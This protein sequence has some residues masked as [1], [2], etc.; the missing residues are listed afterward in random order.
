MPALREAV[1]DWK[2]GGCRGIT[3]TTRI[4]LNYRF[5]T[6]HKLQTSLPFKYHPSQREAIET[7]IFA[8]SSQSQESGQKTTNCAGLT[9]KG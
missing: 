2:A 8:N 5:E 3:E 9:A 6:D 1:R 4:L 7:L